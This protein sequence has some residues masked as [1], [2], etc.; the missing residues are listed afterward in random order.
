ME[1]NLVPESTVYSSD[2]LGQ[3]SIVVDAGLSYVLIQVT[4]SNGQYLDVVH[5]IAPPGPEGVDI[6]IYMDLP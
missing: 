3:A 6:I 2:D 5:P 4:D 1:V